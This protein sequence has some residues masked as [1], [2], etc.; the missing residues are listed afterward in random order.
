MS[1]RASSVLW[2][3]LGKLATLAKIEIVTLFALLC[4]IGVEALAL[5]PLVKAAAILGVMAAYGVIMV[6][7]HRRG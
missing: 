3:L 7:L 6:S 4:V 2:A 5:K 1:G